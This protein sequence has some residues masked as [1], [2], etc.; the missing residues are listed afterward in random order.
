MR[1]RQFSTLLSILAFV[2]FLSCAPGAEF[3][4]ATLKDVFP[5]F[6]AAGAQSH[7]FAMVR[8]P[9]SLPSNALDSEAWMKELKPIPGPDLVKGYFQ[10]W[11]KSPGEIYIKFRR[12]RGGPGYMI[13]LSGIF[14]IEPGRTESIGLNDPDD[15]LDAGTQRGVDR[16]VVE[17]NDQGNRVQATA[18]MGPPPWEIVSQDRWEYWPGGR[19]VRAHS[20]AGYREQ[21]SEDKFILVSQFTEDGKPLPF[22]YPKIDAERV[23]AVCQQFGFQCSPQKDQPGT[24]VFIRLDSPFSYTFHYDWLGEDG[25]AA[26][27]KQIKPETHSDMEGLG[28]PESDTNAIWQNVGNIQRLTVSG[29]ESILTLEASGLIEHPESE[30]LAWALKDALEVDKRFSK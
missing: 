3:K 5:E 8:E 4:A 18:Y 7:Y 24:Y 21:F 17:Y 20:R 11:R 9:L 15:Q 14:K 16:S 12:P 27:L 10:V 13:G 1:K 19:Q 25:C 30:K 22:P 2:V 23:A 26:V 6:A 28:L 29:C